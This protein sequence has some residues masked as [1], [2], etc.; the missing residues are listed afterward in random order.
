MVAGGKSI[1]IGR[2]ISGGIGEFEP[3]LAWALAA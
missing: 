3:A 1:L 2:N